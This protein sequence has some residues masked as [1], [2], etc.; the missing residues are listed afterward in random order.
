MKSHILFTALL[1]LLLSAS[2]SAQGQIAIPLS[3]PGEPGTLSLN[4][5]R[6]TIN[7]SG[8]NDQEVIIRYGNG[9]NNEPQEVT[10]N[11][12]RR[13]TRNAV[14][15]EAAERNNTVNITNVTPM[16]DV[17]FNISVPTNFSLRLNLVNGREIE[18]D[19]VN[20]EME[21][22][23]VNGN[24]TLNDVGGSAVINTVNGNITA[25][26]REVEEGKPM[27]FSN[28]NGKIDVTLPAGAKLTA[29]MN[30]DHGEMFTYFDMDIQPGDNAR[31]RS[32]GSNGY[33]VSVNNWVYGKINGGGPEYLFKTLRGDI[34]LRERNE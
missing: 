26:F 17:H 32:S 15:F 7:V 13:I 29:K 34:Y 31:V 27:A 19:N 9:G 11:G 6:G 10:Q 24:V 25:S 16:R 21:I 18:V 14:G 4:M 1:G 8:H 2:A 28:V 30:T 20:G 22:N 12:L 33:R 3:N 5:V 23:H